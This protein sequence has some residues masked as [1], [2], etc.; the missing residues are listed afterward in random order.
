MVV[1]FCL[2]RLRTRWPRLAMTRKVGLVNALPQAGDRLAGL[3][4]FGLERCELPHQIPHVRV[5]EGVFLLQLP[6]CRH[7]GYVYNGICI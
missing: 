3:F 7:F 1:R 4:L 2:S 6:V 5:Q